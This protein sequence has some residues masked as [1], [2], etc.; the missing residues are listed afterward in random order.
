MCVCETE[1]VRVE[2]EKMK[3][4]RDLLGHVRECVIE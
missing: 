2:D 1:S 4:Q 3:E